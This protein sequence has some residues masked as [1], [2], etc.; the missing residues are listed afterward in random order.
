MSANAFPSKRK[1]KT[2]NIYVWINLKALNYS[3]WGA[4]TDALAKFKM[5]FISLQ[6]PFLPLLYNL[7]ASC[8]QS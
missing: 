3:P 6:T 4:E 1:E 8:L 7:H 5:K 2:M